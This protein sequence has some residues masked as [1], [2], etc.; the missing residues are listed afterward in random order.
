MPI[1][2]VI[3]G[4]RAQLIFHDVDSI[5]SVKSTHTFTGLTLGTAS[6]TRLIVAPIKYSNSTIVSDFGELNSVTLG[7]VSLTRAVRARNGV[8]SNNSEIWYGI[9][10]TGTTGTA[11]L[12]FADNKRYCGIGIYE[13]QNYISASPYNSASD[14]VS[15]VDTLQTNISARRG[16]VLFAVAG[17]R[18]NT[19]GSLYDWTG[20]IEDHDNS[21]FGPAFSL[22]SLEVTESNSSFLIKA[23]L[24]SSAGTQILAVAQWR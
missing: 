13:V 14:E 6:A 7:G 22:A 15:G 9:V 10:P 4:G 16:G 18:S 20:L 8:A 17:L 19:G 21:I 5:D 3:G 1:T 23:V 11:T 24:N 12:T 2:S